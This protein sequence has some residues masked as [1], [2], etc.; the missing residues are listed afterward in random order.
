M[1]MIHFLLLSLLFIHIL[2]QEEF[3]V[4]SK[5]YIDLFYI[6]YLGNIKEILYPNPSNCKDILTIS[7]NMINYEKI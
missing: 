5:I 4:K 6:S 2:S 7:E 1:K 3:E